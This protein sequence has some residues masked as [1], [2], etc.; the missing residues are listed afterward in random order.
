MCR[1][2]VGT[3]NLTIGYIHSILALVMGGCCPRV[4]QNRRARCL[5]NEGT[6]L[7]MLHVQFIETLEEEK[8]GTM[9]VIFQYLFNQWTCS[10][11]YNCTGKKTDS[12]VWPPS[13]PTKSRISSQITHQHLVF[14]QNYIVRTSEQNLFSKIQLNYQCV[15]CAFFYHQQSY[16][17]FCFMQQCYPNE[18]LE[19]VSIQQC[20][21]ITSFELDKKEI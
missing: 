14:I 9:I 21:K 17:I 3:N 6:E 20:Q 19:L 4:T 10:L 8:S 1:T 11:C 18:H 13:S 12:H 5:P 7:Q 16:R 15:F 2:T